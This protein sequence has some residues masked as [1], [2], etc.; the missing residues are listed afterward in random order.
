MKIKWRTIF[1]LLMCLHCFAFAEEK[2][3]NN[4]PII[5]NK[6]KTKISFGMGQD[7]YQHLVASSFIVTGQMFVLQEFGDMSERRAVR[8]AVSSTAA[9]GLSKEIY[10]Y[11][12]KK[13][14]PSVRDLIADACGIGIGI[15]IFSLK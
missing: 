5:E 14:V 1:I 11:V 9:L 8:F 15:L 10:D 7:K 13:G 2:G 3:K 4:E 12:S 6:K